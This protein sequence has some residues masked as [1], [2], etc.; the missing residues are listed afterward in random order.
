MACHAGR[1]LKQHPDVCCLLTLHGQPAPEGGSNISRL[2]LA[3]QQQWDHAA[4]AHLGLID[5]TPMSG[6][7]V[8]WI[9]RQCPDGHLHRWEATVFNRSRGNGCPQCAGRKVCMHNSLASKAPK[10]AAQWDYVANDST[11]DDVVAQ[12]SHPVGWLCEV[13]GEQWSQSPNQRVSK[14]KAGCPQCARKAN[15]KR[16]IK[17][18][19][20]A[21]C[22]DPQGKA[23]L[24]GWDHE[25]NPLQGNFPHNITL[26]ST[27]RIFWLC[28]KCPAG[29]QHSWFAKPL[30]RTLL[31]T[32]CPFCAG[33]RA[34]RCNS[35]QELYP[36]IAAEW[37]YAKNEGRPEDHTAGSHFMAWWSTPQRGSWQQSIH[38]RT[39]YA[40]N[41]ARSKHIQQRLPFANPS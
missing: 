31:K 33:R 41:S 2:A 37:R 10:V 24:E 20:F 8:W 39:N 18:P 11:P 5:I 1:A 6:R 38:A 7:K 9:C 36:A 17:H 22:Q 28:N 34:C 30:H 14:Q 35:L 19:T 27:K 4:N 21:E 3:L 13:C 29:Q 16:K 25:R 23:V 40:H 12:S 32:G 15:R 26:R